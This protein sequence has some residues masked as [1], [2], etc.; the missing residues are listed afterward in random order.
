MD[1]NLRKAVASIQQGL[2]SLD[3]F[4]T[5]YRETQDSLSLEEKQK[6]NRKVFL[7]FGEEG[8]RVFRK[9]NRI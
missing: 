1:K 3:D 9:E 8:Y 2:I 4:D 5:V 6:V 7:S